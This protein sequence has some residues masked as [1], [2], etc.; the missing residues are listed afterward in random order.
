MPAAKYLTEG[1]DG[2]YR[3][4][5]GVLFDHREDGQVWLKRDEIFR[6]VEL[7][8]P[9]HRAPYQKSALEQD[10]QQLVAWGTLQSEQSFA[11]EDDLVRRNHQ[12]TLRPE[13][14]ALERGLRELFSRHDQGSLDPALLTN[15]NEAFLEL[16]RLL[17]TPVSATASEARD[18]RATLRAA[19]R[20]FIELFEA[21]RKAGIEFQSAL[22]APESTA[23]V[24]MD[25]LITYKHLLQQ[26]LNAFGK[27]LR[28]YADA[29][30]GQMTM[31]VTRRQIRVWLPP[32][33]ARDS[34]EAIVRTRQSVDEVI[35]QAEVSRTLDRVMAW[36]APGGGAEAL[37]DA[38]LDGVRRAIND[39]KR[40]QEQLQVG[41]SRRR[42]W[43]Q[44][45]DVVRACS[46]V[47]EARQ[48]AALVLHVP[49]AVH[50]QGR[51]LDFSDTRDPWAEE[52]LIE[53]RQPNV[54]GRRKRAIGAPIEDTSEEREALLEAGGLQRR[55]DRARWADFFARGAV[56]L[57]GSAPIATARLHVQLVRV[58]AECMS[59]RDASTRAPDGSVV[60][61]TRLDG[62]TMPL[63]VLRGPS[64]G[65]L[66]L[67]FVRLAREAVGRP[68]A[69]SSLRL[70]TDR[71]VT[72]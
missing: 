2:P 61:L 69:P 63:S 36:V 22:L 70:A 20:Q 30:D 37:A 19:W 24:S 47:A 1:A 25:A 54:R 16:D 38:A 44:M 11:G 67:P 48:F 10:L 32:A 66:Y 53:Y 17:L 64:T 59:T 12:Y 33:I 52:A 28:A 3:A 65:T 51:V 62:S 29:L 55:E 15:F 42:S 50:F 57:D 21:L 31:W 23:D 56:T 58:V 49:R 40:L 35:L 43:L 6:A 72:V 39:T 14:V 4:I 34:V 9:L 41:D 7:R 71:K 26:N 27:N 68:A 8:W 60:R 46:G 5:V 45:A 18:A 13:T